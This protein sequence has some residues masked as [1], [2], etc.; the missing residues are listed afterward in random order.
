MFSDE[1]WAKI[2]VDTLPKDRMVAIDDPG[3]D[4]EARD[5][6]RMLVEASPN[7]AVFAQP[8]PSGTMFVISRALEVEPE[9]ISKFAFN[10]AL[11]ANKLLAEIG[12]TGFRATNGH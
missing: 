5:V 9:T 6:A 1:E 10:L 12:V 2:L 7:F 8:N 3:W 11:A 4:N